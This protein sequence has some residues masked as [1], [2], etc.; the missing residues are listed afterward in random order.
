MTPA[1]LHAFRLELES[2]EKHAAFLQNVGTNIGNTLKGFTTPVQSLK[3][4]WE[5]GGWSQGGE[6]RNMLA[7][8]LP[9]GAR[10]KNWAGGKGIG[11]HLPGGKA[12]TVATG[13]MMA[14]EALKKEDPTGRGRSRAE[15]IGS[16][17][18]NQAGG[19][20]GTP[21]GLSGAIAGSLVGEGA[22]KVVGKA[23]NKI[24]GKKKKKPEQA[25]TPQVAR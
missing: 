9:V 2:I 14:P 25:A 20:I 10:G 1:M 23:F 19:L 13:L 16:F 3:K 5:V 18:G 4:G 17:I 8:G 6:S 7:A 12:L 21:Y 22:G 15:R 11:R 24:T